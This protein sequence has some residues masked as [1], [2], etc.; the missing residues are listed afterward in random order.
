MKG[1]VKYHGGI[2]PRISRD[3]PEHARISAAH[4][5]SSGRTG[6]SGQRKIGCRFSNVVCSE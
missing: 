3:D 2:F 1:N 5:N 4:R 6:C